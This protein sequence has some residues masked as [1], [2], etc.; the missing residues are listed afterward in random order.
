MD[1]TKIPLIAMATKRMGWLAQRQ[2]VLSQNIANA[3][4]PDY[5]P[6]DVKPQSF[7]KFLQPSAPKMTMTA[8]N[9]HHLEPL[10]RKET[11]RNEKDRETYEVAPSGNAVV[12]EEQL[13]KVA[14]SQMDYRMVTNLYRKHVS[15]IRMAIGRNGR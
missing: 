12:L 3:D 5:V 14:E 4:T 6:L 11:Y 13:M 9:A 7:R 15:M 2:E 8:T 1:L 10:R